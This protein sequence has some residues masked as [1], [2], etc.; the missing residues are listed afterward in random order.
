[1]SAWLSSG[2]MA[3]SNA[4]LASGDMPSGCAPG[5]SEACAAAA[6]CALADGLCWACARTATA[7][8]SEGKSL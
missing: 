7:A 1:M 2:T 3:V 5:A 8:W 6:A 4:P